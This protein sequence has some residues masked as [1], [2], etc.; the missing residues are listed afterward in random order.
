M[1]LIQILTFSILV[2]LVYWTTSQRIQV[3]LLLGLSVVA[4]YWLQPSTSI[5][6]L[7]FW[8]PTL[9]I[10][11]TVLVWVLTQSD[12][13][14]DWFHRGPDLYAFLFLLGL[15]L[16]IGLTRYLGP[17]CCLTPTRPPEL[18]KVILFLGLVSLI[19]I[20]LAWIVPGRRLPAVLA[21]L[22]ILGIFIVLKTDSLAQLTSVLLRTANGQSALLATGLD[23][24]WLGYSYLALRL[25]HVLRDFQSGKLPDYSLGEF[26][27]YVIFFPA[28][29]AGPIDRSQR[30]ISDLRHHDESEVSVQRDPN[31]LIEGGQ[32]VLL[33]IFKKF[34][35]ADG[36]ALIALNGQNAL[37]TSSA[38]WTWILLYAYALRIFF[39]FAGYTDIA[40]GLGRMAGI[41]LP[42]N[43]DRPYFKTNLTA[44]WNSWHITLAQWFRAYFFNPLTRALR[45]QPRKLPAWIVI[46][47]SQI[48]TMLLIG[49]WHG[50]TWN[51]AVW[52]I[53]HG[54]G[55]FIHNRWLDWARPRMAWLEVYPVWR[56]ASQIASW[57]LTF[58]YVALGWVWFALPNLSLAGG[59]FRK[60]AGL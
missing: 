49:L 26:I 32:R 48:S 8:L 56:R 31:L 41:R 52:G 46:L 2:L 17:I 25:I 30:F 34:V 35:L 13:R 47:F 59:L 57:F 23:L 36:L 19:A 7:D 60:L 6:N 15:I 28:L 20:I 12:R 18:I 43:F 45:S 27:T 39:D 21:V 44:F 55:L 42:E 29:T 4:V 11:L 16:A 3:W 38:L 40:I 53:W 1:T 54:A 50:V 22:L 33:G 58:N 24:R 9:S 5:H 51:F 10:L 14:T 37:Q